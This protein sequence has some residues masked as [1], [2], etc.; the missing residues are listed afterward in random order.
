MVK[1][2][3]VPK[4]RFECQAVDGRLEGDKITAFNDL[5]PDDFHPLER[6]H[7]ERGHWFAVH[8]GNQSGTWV[9]FAGFVPF[10]PFPDVA[11]FKRSAVL[12]EYR[13]YGLQRKLMAVRETAARARGYTRLVSSCDI[14]NVHSANNFIREGWLLTNPERPWEPTS[15][16]WVKDL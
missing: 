11:Y 7:L 12:P 5:Y 13:G 6:H 9:A 3:I 14:S 1:V 8:I 16:Y 2:A 10:V 15:L 4:H